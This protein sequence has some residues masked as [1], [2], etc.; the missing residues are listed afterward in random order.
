MISIEDAYKIIKPEHE[1]EI[2]EG[3]RDFGEYYGFKFSPK[4]LAGQ[5]YGGACYHTVNKTDKSISFFSPI[6]DMDKYM[7]A[8][9]VDISIFE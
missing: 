8:T 1:D 2:L 3:C 6:M 9:P 7:E 5:E 4:E